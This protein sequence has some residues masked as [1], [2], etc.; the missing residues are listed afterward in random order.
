MLGPTLAVRWDESLKKGGLGAD[1][2]GGPCARVGI[3][4]FGMGPTPRLLNITTTSK[5][6]SKQHQNTIITTTLRP[7]SIDSA[8]QRYGNRSR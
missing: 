2:G 6:S 1:V 7:R 4:E 5:T 8:F 3:W